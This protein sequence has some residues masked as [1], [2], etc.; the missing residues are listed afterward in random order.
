MRAPALP[1]P[2]RRL[3]AGAA[4]TAAAVAVAFEARWE[5]TILV[6]AAVLAAGAIGFV[7]RGVLSQV[8]GR[9]IAWLSLLPVGTQ[10]VATLLGGHLP[11]APA[12]LYS[13][14][15]S[16]ALLLA[17]PALHT[18]EAKAQ[19]SPVGYRRTFLAGA[20][21]A[22]AVGV[23]FALYA[24]VPIVDG[25][26]AQPP[27]L[28]VSAMAAANLAAAVGV[29]RMRAW[30]VLLAMLASAGALGAGILSWNILEALGLALA[31]IPGALLGAPLLAARLRRETAAPTRP[32]VYA[33]VREQPTVRAR[34]AVEEEV[35]VDERLAHVAGE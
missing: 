9:G 26:M 8:V 29:V 11:E 3:L 15:M 27:L 24:I 16:S 10:V 34:V 17:R 18:D 1:L 33:R 19:F 35:D 13:A 30:G 20:V 23:V 7:R 12:V 6:F 32:V 22:V 28:A 21:A 2:A 31:A 25:D 14:A 4:M 5:R